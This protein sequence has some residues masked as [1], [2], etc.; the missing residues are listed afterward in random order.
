MSATADKSMQERKQK[1]IFFC[2]QSILIFLKY[3][4]YP[5]SKTLSCYKGQTISSICLNF[6][7]FYNQTHPSCSSLL[8]PL[9]HPFTPAKLLS[10]LPPAQL[11]FPVLWATAH[12]SPTY[13]ALPTPLLLKSVPFF[14]PSSST[15]NPLTTPLYSLYSLH[16]YCINH[17]FTQFST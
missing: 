17:S 2:L 10:E 11:S 12:C 14:K 16:F 1:C 6:K 4:F 3:N 7:V 9:P 15:W 8:S 5:F 13:S